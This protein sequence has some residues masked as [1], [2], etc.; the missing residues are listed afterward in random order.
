MLKSIIVGLI[1]LGI[2]DISVCYRIDY[3]F[4]LN[5]PFGDHFSSNKEEEI[6]VISANIN[7]LR[8][9]ECKAKTTYYGNFLFNQKP[10]L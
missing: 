5:E 4:F 8:M 1:Y 6:T 3:T 10:I 9:E 2:E 7:G